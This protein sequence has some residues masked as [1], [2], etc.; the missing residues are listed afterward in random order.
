MS[1]SDSVWNKDNN[2]ADSN[3]IIGVFLDTLGGTGYL[4]DKETG[5]TLY[6]FSDWFYTSP[7]FMYNK[8]EG[9]VKILPIDPKKD[10]VTKWSYS[11]GEV[12]YKGISYTIGDRI[13]DEAFK[14]GNFEGLKYLFVPEEVT[15]RYSYSLTG[16]YTQEELDLFNQALETANLPSSEILMPGDLVELPKDIPGYKLVQ[17]ILP[18]NIFPMPHPFDWEVYAIGTGPSNWVAYEYVVIDKA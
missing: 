18:T 4:F 10:F 1:A 9:Y 15:M 6:S 12:T 14:V 16:E 2:N 8:E 3:L 17:K 11:F 7:Y 13:Y 5:A